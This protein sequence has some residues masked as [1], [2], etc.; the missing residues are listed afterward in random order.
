M[1][2]R[3]AVVV[4]ILSVVLIACLLWSGFDDPPMVPQ[5]GASDAGATEGVGVA[6]AP[7]PSVTDASEGLPERVPVSATKTAAEA[8][9]GPE[10]LWG[11]I[12][13][14]GTATPIP[15]AAVLL[16]HR[17]ADEFSNLDLRYGEQ[18]TTLAR[19]TSGSD[20]AFRF[21]VTRAR[22]HRLDVR[23][24]GYAPSTVVD[25][26]GG[27]EV[28]V[29]LSL[30]AS[31]EGVVRCEG[32]G[33]A[34]VEVHVAVEGQGIVLASGRTEGGG[35]FR[36][37]GLQPATIFVQAGM[38]RHSEVWKRVELKGGEIHRVEMELKIGVALRGR[39][40]EATTRSPIVDAELSDS[41]TFKRIVR[42]DVDGRFVMPGVKD[43]SFVEVHARAPGYASASRNLAGQLGKDA[44]FE[45]VRGGEVSGR[46]VT[47]EGTGTAAVYAA[48][49]ASYAAGPGHQGS[50][51]VRADVA[52]DGRFLASGLRPDQHYWLYV[53]GARYGTRVYALAH[54]LGSGERA[55]VG[56]VVLHDAGGV[57]GRVLDD[58]GLP[59]AGVRVSIHGT[60]DDS[61][62]WLAPD[63]RPETV[64][65]FERRS[66]DTDAR[67]GFRFTSLATGQYE[68]G[69][70]QRGQQKEVS[71][72]VQ[73]RDGAIIEGVEL[74][75]PAGAVIEGVLRYADGRPLG[76]EAAELYLN[77]S[78]K[79]EQLASARPQT[80]G[81]FRFAGLTA[82]GAYTVSILRG[83]PGWS[84][85]P[86]AGVAAGTKDL[87]LVLERSLFVSGRVVDADG[88]GIKSQVYVSPQGATSG[89][90]LHA[91][92]ADGGFRVEVPPDFNGT[93]GA[94]DLKDWMVS[95]NVEGVVAGQQDIVLRL[96]PF[97]GLR[98]R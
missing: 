91:T 8:Q 82:E 13:V 84:L 34:D 24:D 15:N 35:T 6:T 1:H 53:R 12:V 93:V 97:G 17:D 16:Q 5:A 9:P 50:D 70:R 81:T 37:T 98:R 71:A 47:A 72:K 85:S 90:A 36:F 96:K 94:H 61:R 27:S 92:D 59:I 74:V 40:I 80:G 38:P 30:G 3:V 43:E 49:G 41:W 29:G 65:Q 20:G 33:V 89:S 21:P 95:A 63:Q 32:S 66:I 87:Q 10:E 28:V 31:V 46:F 88:K 44:E 52:P 83:P 48:V 60:N 7:A 45:L 67:G 39:V 51:W 69:V 54:R 79:G 73:V 75:V 56:D 14:A 76:D 78:R 2:R 77:A 11:R 58:S 23:A 4:A 25:C 64:S 19:T 68:I 18:V 22:K 57:E 62:A 26:T 55:D 42:T 86:R